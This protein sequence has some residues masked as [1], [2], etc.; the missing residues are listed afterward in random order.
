MDKNTAVVFPAPLI[1]T[2][3]GLSFFL[4]REQAA[5]TPAPQVTINGHLPASSTNGTGEPS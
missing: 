4:T 3:A 2:I 5:A 1:T